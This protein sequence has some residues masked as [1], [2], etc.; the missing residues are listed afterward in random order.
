M[1]FWYNGVMLS[2]G[3]LTIGTMTKVFGLGLLSIIGLV[4]L[5]TRLPEIIKGIASTSLLLKVIKRKPAIP[6]K[7]GKTIPDDQLRGR[8]IFRDITFRYPSLPN[9]VVLQNF[10]LDIQPGQSVALV[11]ASGS[12]KSTIVGLL[13]RWY[14]PE[15]GTIELDGVLLSEIDPQWLHRHLGIVSQEPTLFATTIRKNISYA[16]DTINMNIHREAKRKN[17]H[18]SED[19]I[20]A[21][22][23]PVT[24]EMII[25]AAKAA[26]AH[27]FIVKL[28]NGYDTLIGDRGVSLSG[29][30]KQ[31]IAIARAMLQNSSVLILDEATSALDTERSTRTRSTRSLDGW[32]YNY[33]NSS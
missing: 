22:Q 14:E 29:G 27:D 16:V 9:V 11:G 28:P 25:N 5:M 1:A 2:D 24:E 32:S 8:I 26:N 30:Q 15:I 4:Q 33:C 7:G 3:R 31:R 12:G 17:K 10:N 20:K 23:L 6:F 13:E 21:M 19:E 18:I